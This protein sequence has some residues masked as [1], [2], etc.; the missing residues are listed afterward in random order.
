MQARAPKFS[1]SSR[2]EAGFTP[3]PERKTFGVT[4]RREEGFTLIELLVV[5]AIIGLLSSV[6]LVAINSARVDARDTK[7]VSELKSIRE[8]LRMYEG[9]KGY[10]PLSNMP[11]TVLVNSNEATPGNWKLLSQELSP[12][13]RDLPKHPSGY[14]YSYQYFIYGAGAGNVLSNNCPYSKIYFP[15]GSYYLINILENP[16]NNILESQ[17]VFSP[18][19]SMYQV[20]Y[21]GTAY[22]LPCP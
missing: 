11:G 15:P 12:Y 20:Y 13:I 22:D 9:D 2:S 21:G 8:A 19:L 5:I 7:R 14:M 1:I 17:R 18:F 10:A 16:K 4:S 3:T 6:V